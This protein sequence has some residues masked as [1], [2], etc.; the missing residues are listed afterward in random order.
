MNTQQ[1]QQQK[2]RMKQE[3]TRLTCLFAKNSFVVYKLNIH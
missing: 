2:E 1:Q 3:N